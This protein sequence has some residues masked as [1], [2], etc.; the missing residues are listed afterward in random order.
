MARVHLAWMGAAALL[1]APLAPS[2]DT[3]CPAG[4]AISSYR[5]DPI[6]PGFITI[7]G[8]PGTV[9]AHV[10]PA[11]DVTLAVPLPVTFPFSFYGVAKTQVNVCTNGYVD[12]NAAGS[13]IASNRHPGDASAPNDCAM[14]WHDDLVVVSPTSSV[15]Y[16][17]GFP[18]GPDTM[19]VQW[20]DVG[21]FVD[22]VPALTG[23]GSFT[24]QCVLYSGMHP[25]FPNRVEYRYDRTTAPPVM[26]PC[27]TSPTNGTIVYATSST[28]GTDNASGASGTNHG[29]DSTERGAGNHVFPPCDLRLTPLSF[30]GGEGAQGGT[31][32]LA[33]QEPFC[34]IAGLPGTV[35]VGAPCVAGA[36]Y[37]DDSSSRLDGVAIDLPWKVNYFGRVMRTATMGTNGLLHLGP[38]LWSSTANFSNLAVSPPSTAD[39]E[40]ML[41]P[42]WDDL[43]GSPL[44]GMFYRVDGMPG[45]RV[46]T[47]EWLGFGPFL[48]PGADC[49]PGAGSISF[50]VKLYEGSAGGLFP[51]P[52]CYDPVPGKGNDRIEFHYDHAGFVP[53]PFTATIGIENHKGTVGIAGL[54]GTA[55][56]APPAGGSKVV[57]DLCD[58]GQVR[59]YG[60]ATTIPGTTLPA[61]ELKTNGVPALLGNP[62]A[63]EVMASA[64]PGTPAFSFLVLDI[65]GPIPGLK[66]PVPCGGAPFPGVG[67]LWVNLASSL[68]FSKPGCCVT[69]DLPIPAIPS[70]VGG[71]LFA[72]GA[73]LTFGPAGP[74]F[75]LTEGGK[76][77]IG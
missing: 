62:F 44:S 1:L 11:D 43:E 26:S 35:A 20:T 21:N 47:F 16:N 61:A 51:T 74:V 34:S 24:F 3:P 59:Y 71:V 48:T 72:Q 25:M 36:C 53:G 45:C 60:D 69:Y 22:V 8:D 64:V 40:A 58:F 76:L 38:G 7:L 57:F 18:Y 4:A 14:A 5:S 46:M 42:F 65:G 9:T 52:L 63:L 56:V 54:P 73:C 50:Q 37:E 30:T 23:R 55:N 31:A 77:I 10:P 67:T 75:L 32:V 66:T 33:L 29:H 19:T 28:I 17:F 68:I 12:F 41:A 6:V 70:L 2:Q 15:T 27:Q 39:P 13:T 49:T